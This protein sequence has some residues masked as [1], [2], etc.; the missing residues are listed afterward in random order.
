M[1]TNFFR[2]LA[3][4][5]IAG[6]LQITFAQTVENNFVASILL[7]NEQCGD[8][9]R[10]LIPSLNLRIKAEELDN[11][12]FETITMPL[13]TASRLIVEWVGSSLLWGLFR[14][15]LTENGSFSSI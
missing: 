2:Q 11:G 8:K 7:N 9:A 13:Q 12:F 5:N 3:K 1:Q 6:D 4:L 14:N 15:G 10:K